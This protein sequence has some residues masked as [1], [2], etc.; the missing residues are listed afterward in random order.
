MGIIR[1]GV[2]INL[3]CSDLIGELVVGCDGVILGITLDKESF[4]KNLPPTPTQTCTFKYGKIA[5]EICYKIYKTLI[6]DA[7]TRRLYQTLVFDPV[8][9]FL[10]QLRPCADPSNSP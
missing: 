8:Y 6:L 3:L 10:F 5:G 7:Y 4:L 2:L 9:V 1:Q